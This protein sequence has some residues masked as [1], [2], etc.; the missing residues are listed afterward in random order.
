MGGLINLRDE[1]II[2]QI[3]E[4][5]KSISSFS[6]ELYEYSKQVGN[7]QLSENELNFFSFIS[8]QIVFLKNVY[9]IERNYKIKVLISDYYNYIV[10]IIKNEH[11]YMY[12]NER[13][14]IE[15]YT[16]WIVSTDVEKNYITNRVFEEFKTKTSLSEAE[17]KLIKSAYSDS[18]G[19]IHGS[20]ILNDDLVY[21]FKECIA[22]EKRIKNMNNYFTSFMRIIKIYNRLIIC[23]YPDLIDNSFFRRKSV[24]KYLV[25]E[26]NLNLL[27]EK[28]SR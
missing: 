2:S 28:L 11:R 27:F 19:Y 26:E 24:L 13:S 7:H 3:N 17:Y 18:C 20:T 10:S 15:N 21:V 9:E 14:I 4:I 12:V 25:G 16:R 8:K 6:N 5:K 22:N 1:L 23:T